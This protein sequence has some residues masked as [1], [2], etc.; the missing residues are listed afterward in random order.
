MSR[1]LILST[2]LAGFLIP[3][4][5]RSLHADILTTFQ[6]LG[7]VRA[8]PNPWRIDRHG[9]LPMVFDQIPAA[10]VATL[11]IFTISGELVRTMTGAQNLQWDLRNQGGQ[12]VA[13]G[14]YLY[15]LT[16]D[17]QKKTG[18]VVVIR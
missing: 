4:A 16:A 9:A 5:S 11:R 8:Y 18:K 6:D 12:N 10:T 17:N 1:L 7:A 13:S 14:V 2:L 15:L 3:L